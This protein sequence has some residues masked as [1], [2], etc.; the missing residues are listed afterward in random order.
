M[1]AN[2]MYTYVRQDKPKEQGYSQEYISCDTKYIEEMGAD[3]ETLE[4]KP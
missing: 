3:L 1:E 4:A 2:R